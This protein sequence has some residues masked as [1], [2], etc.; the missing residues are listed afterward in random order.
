MLE[1]L[2]KYKHCHNGLGR[3]KTKE[4]FDVD[5]VIML[6]ILN[7]EDMLGNRANLYGRF[8]FDNLSNTECINLFRFHKEDITRLTLAFNLPATITFNRT[9]LTGR[10]ALCMLL[11]RLTYP[12]RLVDLEPLFG[13]STTINSK[14][15]NEMLSLIYQRKGHLLYNLSQVQHFNLI[16][17]RHSQAIHEAGCPLQNCWGFIDGTARL[18]CRPSINQQNY[19]SGHRRTHY[20]KYQSV[21]C[22]D[23][24][25]INLKGAYEGR[26]HDAGIFKESGLYQ[27]L[28]E[29]VVFVGIGGI[30]VLYGDQAYEHEIGLEQLHQDFNNHMKVLRVSV[31]WGFGK[32]LQLF[33]FLDFKKNQ[34]LLLQDVEAMYKVGVILTNCDTCLYGSETSAYF[35]VNPP[36]L[37]EYLE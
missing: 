17:L 4:D 18:I 5:D 27:E 29:N 3:F 1:K 19:Y 10:D 32:I 26:R 37:E 36:A 2:W 25:I 8:L 34:K 12:N 30:F 35:N 24:L 21:V 6:H 9:T 11:R 20:V 31:E 28:E 7:D 22:P 14:A 23:G 13:F 16:K 15:C 33:A